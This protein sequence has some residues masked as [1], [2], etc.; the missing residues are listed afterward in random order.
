M[1]IAK[2]A[3]APADATTSTSIPGCN[4]KT[5]LSQDQLYGAL[6]N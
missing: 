1:M 5:G 6:T 2:I 4:A 3:E